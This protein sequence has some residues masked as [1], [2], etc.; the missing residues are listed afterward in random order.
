[1]GPQEHRAARADFQVRR[2]W[3]SSVF[4]VEEH[5]P[6]AGN[7]T[8]FHN[9]G[10][11]SAEP[12]NFVNMNEGRFVC[13]LFVDSASGDASTA[14]ESLVRMEMVSPSEWATPP[15]GSCLFWPDGKLASAREFNVKKTEAKLQSGEDRCVQKTYANT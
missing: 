1:M 3:G 14:L 9:S 7:E 6:C 8:A 12:S 4:K 11:A 15:L 5:R 2:A 10:Y 13:Q